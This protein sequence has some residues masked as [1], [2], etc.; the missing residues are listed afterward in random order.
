MTAGF[1]VAVAVVFPLLLAILSL[2]PRLRAYVQRYG[3][4]AAAWP[5]LALALASVAFD[6]FDVDWLLLGVRIAPPDSTLR[7]V[8]LTTAL[9]WSFAGWFARDYIIDARRDSFWCFFFATLGGNVGVLVAQDVATFY[10]S[11]VVMTFAAYGLIVHERSAD[12][13]RAGRVYLGMAIGAEVLLLAAF[14]LIVCS[15]IDIPLAEAPRIVAQRPDRGLVIALLLFGFGVKVGI[16]PVH[17]WLPLAHPV[18]PTPASAILSGTLIKA[19]VVGWLRFLPLGLVAVPEAGIACALL[20]LVST[21]YASAIGS[22]QREPK[23][24]LAYSSI[25]QMGFVAAALGAALTAPSTAPAVTAS[26]VLFTQYHMLTKGA[27]FLGLGALGGAPKAAGRRSVT[28]GTLALA[29]SIAG[30]PLTSGAL[31]KIALTGAIARVPGAWTTFGYLLS[32]GAVGSTLLM[33]R[34]SSLALGSSS[35]DADADAARPA[36]DLVLPWALLAGTALVLP[37]VLAR[38]PT[39]PDTLLEMGHL[40][41]AAW[42]ILAGGAIAVVGSREPVARRLRGVPPGDVLVPTTRFVE[43]ISSVSD[44]LR[45]QLLSPLGP[46]MHAARPRVTGWLATASRTLERVEVGLGDARVLGS[47]L[48]LLIIIVFACAGRR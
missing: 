14:W 29:A 11:Y 47:M 34:F 45:E 21:L 39:A 31:A 23:T 28:L 27:L 36:R 41:S 18:A 9:L 37:L 42:P 3:S 5:A 13:W 4:I 26:I 12:V 30:A 48:L 25:S 40:T 6:P 16:V 19:G 43:R 38:P 17:V 8:L 35:P 33:I 7:S 22:I 44:S 2:V 10:L 15:R 1:L 20:G 32:V 24:V 46:R